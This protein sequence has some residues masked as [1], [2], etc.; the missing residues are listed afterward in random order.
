MAQGPVEST[1]E[2]AKTFV[3]EAQKTFKK[4]RARLNK[5]LD[6]GR[7]R[8]ESFA[9]KTR[10]GW[11]EAA[12]SRIQRTVN[13]LGLPTSGQVEELSGRVAKLTRRVNSLLKGNG[14]SESS[15]AS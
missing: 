14:K 1:A 13:A 9:E 11:G 7:K 15:R 4:R 3:K 12:Q 5:M 8:L 10:N 6:G 2:F